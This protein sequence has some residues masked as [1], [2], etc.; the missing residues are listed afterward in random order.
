[1]SCYFFGRHATNVL[2]TSIMNEFPIVFHDP[3]T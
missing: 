2:S 1:M 3:P